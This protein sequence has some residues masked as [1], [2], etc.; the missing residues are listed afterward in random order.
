MS[1]TSELSTNSPARIQWPER[2]FPLQ[3]V[4]EWIAAQL[5]LPASTRIEPTV[6]YASYTEAPD[7]RLT[8]RFNLTH[9]E[10][11]PR[12]IVFKANRMPLLSGSGRA[13]ALVS[14]HATSL[15]PDIL[16]WEQY[17]PDSSFVLYDP[18]EGHPLNNDASLLIRTS[19]AIAAIQ[20]AVADSGEAR[21][22][23]IVCVRAE[24]I[25][26]MFE[27]VYS[28]IE[29]CLGVWAADEGQK[30]SACL[31]MPTSSVL[32]IL[33]AA[34]PQIVQ[35]S[36]MVSALGLPLTIDHGDLHEG[37]ACLLNNNAILIFDW[38]TA[39]VGCPLFSVEKLLV[40]AW[41][42]DEHPEGSGPWG[43]Q[44]CTPTQALVRDSYLSALGR[45][46]IDSQTFAAAMSL[47][48]VKEMRTEIAWANLMGWP[49]GNPEWTAQ[50][51]A[52]MQYHLQYTW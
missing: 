19:Q 52:R 29:A 27:E 20:R 15:V 2:A 4:Q 45:P 34:R 42:C 3:E 21:D 26:A 6:I 31:G 51:L 22:S 46:D 41:R 44:P 13:H 9:S 1:Q 36:A 28:H 5:H 24:D 16:A 32:E 23:Q 18:F 12:E 14:R 40:S 33:T 47:A 30:L 50:L 25:P 35:C 49:N 7:L 11:T 38:E 17:L 48:V 10:L 37:N 8:A 39:T 43:Y